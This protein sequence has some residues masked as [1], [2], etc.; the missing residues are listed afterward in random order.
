MGIFSWMF[1]RRESKQP[2][3]MAGIYGITKDGCYLIM[4][5]AG[6]I[7]KSPPLDIDQYLAFHGD[8]IPAAEREQLLLARPYQTWVTTSAKPQ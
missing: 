1:G 5:E 7:T 8:N 3:T 2:V 6:R 4:D